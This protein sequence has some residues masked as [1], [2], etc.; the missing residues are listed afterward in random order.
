M[1]IA[2]IIAKLLLV[3]FSANSFVRNINSDAK[4][5]QSK[6]ERIISIVASATVF[7]GTLILF[8]LAGVLDYPK[9]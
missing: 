4:T 5:I 8:F 6:E 1:F 7:I 3:F 9:L 2:S